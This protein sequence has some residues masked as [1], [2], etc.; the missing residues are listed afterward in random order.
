MAR[1]KKVFSTDEV[2]H[3]WAHETQEEA[4][5]STGNVSFHG[6]NAKSYATVIATIAKNDKGQ[7]AYL[8]ATR[9]YSNTTCKHQG[10]IRRSI[11][12]NATS[13]GLSEVA[14][15][16]S[17]Y[18]AI[19]T[20]AEM[21]ASILSELPGL[22]SAAKNARSNKDW[23]TAQYIDRVEEIK[24]FCAFFSLDVPEL[25]TLEHQAEAVKNARKLELARDK[26]R[27]RLADD[28]AR[29]KLALWL[30]GGEVY[31]GG[32]YGLS[33]AF[34]RLSPADPDTLETTQGATVPAAHVKR[35][36]KL[37]LSLVARAIATGQPVIPT[38][39]LHFGHYRLDGISATGIVTVGCH[40]FEASEITR[41][42]ALLG[43]AA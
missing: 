6:A 18:S 13:F 12:R 17:W 37:V 22:A 23:K 7:T 35:G 42:A 20:P 14:G 10:L 32:F 21:L 16:G 3:L 4:R 11:P 29:E 19:Y 41:V 33:S 26:E 15:K 24:K 27:A 43:E 8:Y 31:H 39:D 30:D 1:E 38:R 36:A 2:Y 34:M 40:K 25:P 28:A 5:N 9:S